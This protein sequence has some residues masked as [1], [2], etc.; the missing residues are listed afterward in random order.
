[1]SLPIMKLA[2]IFERACALREVG[3]RAGDAHF[4][5]GKSIAPERFPLL[6]LFMS[7]LSRKSIAPERFPLLRLFMSRLSKKSLPHAWDRHPR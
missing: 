1:M 6:R 2:S 4:G 3:K 7:R 5:F